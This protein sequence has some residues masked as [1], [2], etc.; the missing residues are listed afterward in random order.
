MAIIAKK[1]EVVMKIRLIG[2]LFVAMMIIGGCKTDKTPTSAFV[3]PDPN[4]E[5]ELLQIFKESEEAGVVK[6][7]SRNVYIG[8]DVDIVLEAPSPE[9][10]PILVASAFQLLENTDFPSRAEALATEIEKTL[11]HLIGLQEMSKFY[12]QSPGDVAYGGTVPATDKF[13]DFFEVLMENGGAPVKS[14]LRMKMKTEHRTKIKDLKLRHR[15][16][17]VDFRKAHP[18]KKDSK[19]G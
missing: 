10:I 5:E 6:V 4:G 8:T 14:N 11:P 7:M 1:P 18:L 17:Q 3:D 19:K 15:K 12:T 13:L 9:T 16:E 2:T